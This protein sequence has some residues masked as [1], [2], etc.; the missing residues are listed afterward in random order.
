MELKFF[1]NF[2]RRRPFSWRHSLFLLVLHNGFHDLLFA[3]FAFL[4]EAGLQVVQVI[5]IDLL[6]LHTRPN[7]ARR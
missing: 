7:K 6:A 2:L 5:M 1:P 4:A 3:V